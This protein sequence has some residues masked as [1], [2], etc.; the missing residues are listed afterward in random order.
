MTE[1]TTDAASTT[2][3]PSTRRRLRHVIPAQVDPRYDEARRLQRARIGRSL[4]RLARRP[5]L[6]RPQLYMLEVNTQ[7]G[8]T[9][10]SL[11]PEQA[12]YVGI[13]SDLVAWMV[14][15]AERRMK[16]RPALSRG[17]RAGQP[18]PRVVPIWRNG[19]ALAAVCAIFFATLCGVVWLS[20][21]AGMPQRR[22]A[23]GIFAHREFREARVRGPRRVRRR[24]FGDSATLYALAVSRGTPIRPSISRQPEARIQRSL[25]PARHGPARSA[26]HRR[27]R[28]HRAPAAGDMAAR[29]EVRADRRRGQDPA[30][31]R[32]RLQPL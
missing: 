22:G 2:T 20:W 19:R 25:G 1:I 8:M 30:Q 16:L 7:P 14:E 21:Q 29:E 9:P 24:P 4:R 31:R 15:N 18:R 27:R 11:V 6:R 17:K 5:P 13:G 32:R 26:G 12:A 3:T 10:T 23:R 28:D